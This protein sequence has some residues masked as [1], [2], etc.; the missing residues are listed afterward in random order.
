MAAIRDICMREAAE[1]GRIA[2]GALS[3]PD[4]RRKP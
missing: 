1:A 4:R 2:A 3:R